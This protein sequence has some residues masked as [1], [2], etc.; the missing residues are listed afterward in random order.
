[1]ILKRARL[2]SL[3]EHVSYFVGDRS[4]QSTLVLMDDLRARL[5]NQVQLTTD[6]HKAY[7]EAVEGAFGG[8]VDHA[9]LVKIYGEAPA[10]RVTIA[11]PSELAPQGSDRRRPRS[12]VRIDL[13][14]RAREPVD[15]HR[16][17]TR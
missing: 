15:P 9:L 8:D 14:R 4:G 7:L 3:A 6:G 17:L 11:P 12:E 1:M 5:A 2:S 13:A 16:R 10:P